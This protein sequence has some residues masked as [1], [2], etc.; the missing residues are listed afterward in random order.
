MRKKRKPIRG[1]LI[2]IVIAAALVLSYVY[3]R[4]IYVFY[5]RYYW[6]TLR[7]LTPEDQVE[8]AEELFRRGDHAGAADLL[9]TLALVYPDNRDIAALY[10]RTLIRLGDGVRGADM[11]LLAYGREKIPGELLEET[12]RALFVRRHYRDILDIFR[13]QAAG[14]N[15]NLLFYYGIA[16]FETG[17][18]GGAIDRLT[19]ALREGRRD[20][21]VY[22]FLGRAHDM[23]GDTAGALPHLERARAMNVEDPR[24]ARSLAKAYRK[25][26]RYDDAEKILRALKRL[27]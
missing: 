14:Q 2:V 15:P 26:G 21:E 9:R 4:R 25:L 22:L 20:H 27:P 3:S 24:V 1:Y 6:E 13:R 19:A 23:K 7:K 8:K 17:D 16:L 11:I 12:V 18:Y 5:L 10:G